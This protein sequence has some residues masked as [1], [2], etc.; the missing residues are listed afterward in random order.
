MRRIDARPGVWAGVLTLALLMGSLTLASAGEDP[1]THVSAV[2][3]ATLKKAVAAHK[4]KVVV[5]NLWATWCGPCVEEFPDLVKLQQSYQKQGLVLI[6]A[7][8]DEPEDK[9]EV[10]DFAR[11][12]NVAFPIYLRKAGSVEKFIDPIDRK[13][14]G[15]V[16]ATYV[17]DR[18]GKLVGKPITGKHTYDEFAAAVAPHLK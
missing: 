12:Q 9:Q 6:A 15:A 14:S 1:A 8:I 2:D 17:F 10:I 3:G 13:W 4:G 11:K 18:K 16:P 5:L 7:S